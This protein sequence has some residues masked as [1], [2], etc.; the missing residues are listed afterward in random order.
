MKLKDLYAQWASG[1]LGKRTFIARMHKK[2]QALF[3]YA[4]YLPDTDVESITIGNGELYVT[5]KESGVKLLIDREDSRF[6]PIE[7]LNFHSIDPDERR[8][9]FEAVRDAETVMDIGAN[10]GW[11]SLSFARVP[12]VKRVF[13]FEPIPH[14]FRYLERHIALNDEGKTI[15]AFNMGL[16][17]VIEEKVFFWSSKEYGAASMRNIQARSQIE[18]IR[19]KVTTLDHFMKKRRVKIDVIKCDVEGAELGV[20]R[21]GLDTLESHRPV[22]YTE[23]LRKWSKKF[24]YHPNDIIELLA[25][26][27]YACFAFADG[28][29]EKVDRVTEDTVATDFFFF[30]E[31]EHKR[32]I[33]ALR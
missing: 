7:M 22:V 30:H 12:S 33:K 20:F 25:G 32:R 14:T 16:S 4:D 17:D 10:I 5:V 24:G 18:K 19:C 9:L 13:S 31:R 15:S 28:K 21:G 3:E 29:P 6:I 8:L 1:E 2:H 11:F 26:I 27:G 23:M